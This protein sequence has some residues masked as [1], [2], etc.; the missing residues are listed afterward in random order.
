MIL[1]C[2]FSIFDW[3]AKRKKNTVSIQ[4]RHS[5]CRNRKS[6]I[7][8]LKWAVLASAL[9]TIVALAQAQHP[10]KIHRIGF[11]RASAPPKAYIEGFRQG[12]RE[13]GYTEGKNITI[14]YRSAEGE[15][16]RLAELAADLVDLKVDIIV[17][18]GTNAV[19]AAKDATS[20]IPIVIASVGDPV[21][22]GLVANLA[23][24]GG[25][26]TGV[27]NLSAEL[28]GKR[29]ELLKEIVPRLARV[30]LPAPKSLVNEAYLKETEVPARALGIQLLPLWFRTDQNFEIAFRSATKERADALLVR[31]LP[32]T[33]ST[34]RKW[35]VDF[36][37]KSRLPA[38]YEAGDWVE[39][40][41]LI[42][43]GVSQPEIFRRAASFVDRILKG[44]KPADLPVE[45]PTKFE[46]VINLKTAKQIGVTIPQSVLYRADKVIK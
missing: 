39:T 24:P 30:A 17:A 13:F 12:L 43:Y 23:R 31:L 9:L 42:S 14:D 32:A 8:N 22:E 40:G 10:G 21:R 28:G 2:R 34:Q 25:N 36:S 7:Q 26:I 41:G 5:Q 6:K 37:A 11:L 44:A 20:R 16:D 18:S 45:R 35:I 4:L 3:R 15:A 19:Q 46:M 1:D 33:T 38:L 29:L 27:T